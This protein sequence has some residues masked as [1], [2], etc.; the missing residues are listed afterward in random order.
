MK[1]LT[2]I[3]PTPIYLTFTIVGSNPTMM[4]KANP[5]T[6]NMT[7]PTSSSLENDISSRATLPIASCNSWQ[8]MSPPLLLL[9][10]IKNHNGLAF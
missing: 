10:I 6:L 8:P 7:T 9:K 2:H 3:I 1:N 4:S 5:V